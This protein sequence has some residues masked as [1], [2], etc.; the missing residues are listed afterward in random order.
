MRE[1]SFV[2]L[3]LLFF[4]RRGIELSVPG[5]DVGA[6]AVFTSRAGT[7]RGAV[8]PDGRLALRTHASRR[9]ASNP[10]AGRV[11][12]R[13]QAKETEMSPIRLAVLA[14]PLALAACGGSSREDA[15]RDAAP[16]SAALSIDVDA[17][18]AT[19]ADA[20]T[21]EPASLLPMPDACHPL[22]FARTEAVA[23]RLNRHFGQALRRIEHVV[24][25]HPAL[26]TDGEF[27]WTEQRDG[28][29]VRFT[30]TRTGEV[31]TWK[32]ELGPA[33]S[34]D[35]V[36]VFSG[37]IDRTGATSPHQ[38]KGEMKLDLDALHSVSGLDVAGTLAATFDLSAA[39]RL[40]QIRA[41]GV[42]WDPDPDGD[43]ARIAP[44]DATYTFQRQPGVGGSL[45][46]EDSMIFFCPANP[47]LAPAD[48]L[49]VSRWVFT[50]GGEVH[51]RSDAEA[52]GGQIATGH[53][54]MGV[55]CHVRPADPMTTPSERFWM[56]KEEDAAG[57]TVQSWQASTGAD[58]CD[59][60]FGPV[61]SASDDLTDF[62]FAGVDPTV[63]FPFPGKV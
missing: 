60:V 23:R 36:T 13:A 54:W 59:P 4:R 47:Q 24:A 34:G 45:V 42:K 17:G 39:K 56:V 62:D 40:V 15:F 37:D 22:L 52:T 1:T 51:G 50:P 27:V 32:L 25:R 31:F 48:A 8:R 7:A 38:G 28:L 61:P 5:R 63:P 19:T 55:T 10:A 53:A 58:A 21:A 20:S 57:A 3:L 33:G 35:F 43:L 18:A 29:D 46:L 16:S 9:A 41:A 6:G 11:F 49:L 2:M 30:M 14:V 44:L 12:H 26:A